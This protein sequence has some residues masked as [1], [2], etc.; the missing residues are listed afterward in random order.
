MSI[1]PAS[2]SHIASSCDSSNGEFSSQTECNGTERRVRPSLNKRGRCWSTFIN[3]VGRSLGEPGCF[4]SRVFHEFHHEVAGRLLERGQLRVSWMELDGSPAAAEYH[5]AD[6]K[7]TYAY[8]G[9]VDPDRLDEEPGRLSTILCLRAAIEEGHTQIDFLRGD[10]PYKAHWRAT[11]RSDL[12][13]PR[14]SQST[15]GPAAGPRVD[16]HRRDRRLGTNRCREN[17]GLRV[18]SHVERSLT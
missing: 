1:W 2:Q 5:V 11:P 8:Q 4:A 6:T 9:G 3:D 17:A 12:R 10:E 14:D 15:A 18:C 7:A 13:L 16:R